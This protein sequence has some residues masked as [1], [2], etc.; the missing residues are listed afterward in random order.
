MEAI[1]SSVSTRSEG[2]AI[3]PTGTYPYREKL[4]G[5][6]A[7]AGRAPASA[8][9]A[10]TSVDAPGTA[11]PSGAARGADPRGRFVRARGSALPFW[12]PGRVDVPTPPIEGARRGRLPGP[13]HRRDSR[14]PR[15]RGRVQR[16]DEEDRKS[17]G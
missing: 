16:H 2:H 13:C 7:L 3:E 6:P 4:R 17:V 5:T 10:S 11:P 12:D 8:S 1:S 15:E 9:I 14:Q